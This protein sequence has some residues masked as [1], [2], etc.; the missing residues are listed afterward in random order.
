MFGIVALS[1]TTWRPFRKDGLLKRTQPR[2]GA[3]CSDFVLPVLLLPK[4]HPPRTPRKMEMRS[5]GDV[6][7][8]KVFDVTLDMAAWMDVV[9]YFII[10]IYADKN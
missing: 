3:F 6:W 8:S 10:C 5:R 4:V 9:F 1:A 7:G 2:C